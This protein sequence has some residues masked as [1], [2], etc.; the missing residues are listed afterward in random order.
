MNIP[1]YRAK[2]IDSDE[3]I[4]GYYIEDYGIGSY[5]QISK[6]LNFIIG[7]RGEKGMES[8][9]LYEIDP[10]TLAIHFKDM[11]D[12][13]G[14]KIFASLS[15]KGKGGDILDINVRTET[16]FIERAVIQTYTFKWDDLKYFKKKAIG[17]QE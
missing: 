12:S 13:E 6:Y 11:A 4:E 17:I 15:E 7:D 8:D 16:L 10:T 14:N 9:C 2:K 3:Y 5:L 1:I